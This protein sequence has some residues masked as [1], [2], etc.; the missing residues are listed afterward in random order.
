[1][2]DALFSLASVGV[3]GVNVHTL[4]GADSTSWGAS[5]LSESRGS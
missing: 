4:P 5:S 3:D 1:M 2:V